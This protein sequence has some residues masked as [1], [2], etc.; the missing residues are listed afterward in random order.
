MI[1]YFKV[2]IVTTFHDA[3]NELASS[4]L[5]ISNSI[6]KHPDY[7]FFKCDCNDDEIPSNWE[8]VSWEW[9]VENFGEDPFSWDPNPQPPQ[10]EPMPET[11][12]AILDTA[13]NMEYLLSLQELGL[14][15]I[16]E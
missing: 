4:G 2:P 15:V 10:P 12:Q 16:S 3:W 6:D 13:V 7:I 9:L 11:D 5:C 14:L 8:E 1:R